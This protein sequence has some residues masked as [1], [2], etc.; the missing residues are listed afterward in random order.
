MTSTMD[1]QATYDPRTHLLI[2]PMSRFQ[3]VAVAV[4]V[5]LCALDGFDVLA[6]TFAAPGIAAEWGIGKT[7]LGFVFSA[8]LLGVAAGS[9]FIAPAADY[10]GRR[11]M[12]LLS[13][14]VMVAGTFWTALTGSI[15]TL[16]LSRVF[17]GL[18]IGAMIA[19]INP[20]AAEYANA[21]R[22]DLAVSLVNIGY[23]AGG[24]LGGLLAAAVLPHFGWRAVFVCVALLCVVMAGVVLLALPEPLAF[25]IARPKVDGLARINAYLRRGGHPA[26]ATLPAA[27]A[28]RRNP[29]ADLFQGGMA[30][31]TIKITAV[32]LLNIV[33]VFYMQTWVPTLVVDS[34]FTP[35][36]AATVSMWLNIGGIFGGLFIGLASPRFG[37]KRIV[38]GTLVATS[39]L[40][41]LFGSAPADLALLRGAALVGGFCVFASMVGVYAVVA[42]SFP[43]RMRASGTGF[44][45]GIG[46]LG[47]VASPLLASALFSTGLVR[48]GVSATMAAPAL[49]AAVV[50]VTLAVR[51]PQ[52]LEADDET[53]RR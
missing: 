41:N 23:P 52:Q 40:I 3:I 42:R 53:E 28:K 17:T 43:A 20:L 51:T 6:V 25:L 9:F 50:L 26:A 10:I 5:A 7:A 47:S 19:V 49:V 13:L 38:V 29:V 15:G 31:V 30:L 1:D 11:P 2:A 44:A 18:G 22:R 36:E 34:G 21:R 16:A 39:I 27:S 45:I 46:R 12:V 37:L 48:A 8:G 35:A 33:P 4:T 24:V 32:Y 14:A